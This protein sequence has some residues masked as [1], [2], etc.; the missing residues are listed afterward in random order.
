MAQSVPQGQ[1]GSKKAEAAGQAR[2]KA[3]EVAG[4][5]QDKAKEAAGQAKGRVSDQVN[6]RSTQAGE[7]VTGSAQDVRTVAEELRK[8][9]KDK[10]AQI[11]EQAANRVEKVGDYLKN[12]DGDR[13]LHDVENFARKNSWA[14]AAGSVAAGF[15]VSRLLKASSS[16]RYRTSVGSGGYGGSGYQGRYGG[17]LPPTGQ[18]SA[19][20]DVGTTSGLGAS[21][22]GPLTDRDIGGPTSAQGGRGDATGGATGTRPSQ[23]ESHS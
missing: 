16:E 4:Q 18:S 3:G 1:S 14:V 5:A 7:Q 19:G 9:G 11:A 21:G 6:Q 15:A 12:S 8:Q 17:S 13:I 20:Y 2:E 10:P 23:F 22:S